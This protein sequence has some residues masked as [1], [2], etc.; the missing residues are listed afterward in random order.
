[1]APILCFLQDKIVEI[2]EKIFQYKPGD[3]V[4]KGIEGQAKKQLDGVDS[5]LAEASLKC[6]CASWTASSSADQKRV[7]AF[8]GQLAQYFVRKPSDD[9]DFRFDEARAA[10]TEL[11]KYINSLSKNQGMAGESVL[12]LAKDLVRVVA[13]EEGQQQDTSGLGDLLP[14]LSAWRPLDEAVQKLEKF[15]DKSDEDRFESTKWL[16]ALQEALQKLELAKAAVQGMPTIVASSGICFFIVETSIQLLDG[17]GPKYQKYVQS[18]FDLRVKEY[19]ALVKAFG[20]DKKQDWH[21][22]ITLME[23]EANDIL[24][25]AV[26][27]LLKLDSSELFKFEGI[28]SDMTEKFKKAYT[29]FANDVPEDFLEKVKKIQDE[30]AV[31]NH[32]AKLAAQWH[33]HKSSAT[34]LAKKW[35]RLRQNLETSQMAPLIPEKLWLRVQDVTKDLHER[36]K[37]IKAESQSQNPQ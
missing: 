22:K 34:T 21:H 3:R 29:M 6:L 13:F 11:A 32:I 17:L 8:R 18:S 30:A 26:T 4:F 10:A 24:K 35:L 19:E 5:S 7:D 15:S 20:P 33:Q 27:T 16:Q 28:F 14:A 25:A 1:M 9:P 2:C 23:A 12:P 31:T 36:K 37:N